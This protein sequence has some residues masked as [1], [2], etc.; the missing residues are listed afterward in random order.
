MQRT[1]SLIELTKHALHFRLLAD[2]GLQ[3]NDFDA[4]LPQ[5]F[6]QAQGLA[7]TLVVIE[8]NRPALLR[9]LA[10]NRLSNASTGTRDEDIFGGVHAVIQVGYWL[11]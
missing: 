3:T 4:H 2:I 6:G 7:L 10:C 5:L 11:L 9:R 1:Q 8:S